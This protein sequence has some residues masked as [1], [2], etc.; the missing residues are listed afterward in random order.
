MIAARHTQLLRAIR[1]AVLGCAGLTL[2]ACS[3]SAEELARL[4]RLTELQER[5]AIADAEEDERL[6][7]RDIVVASPSQLYGYSG[8]EL[9]EFLEL[10]HDGT[11]LQPV[12]SFYHQG[13]TVEIA[14]VFRGRGTYLPDYVPLQTPF[15]RHHDFLRIYRPTYAFVLIDGTLAWIANEEISESIDAL[16]QATWASAAPENTAPFD[17]LMAILERERIEGPV[18]L[19]RLVY[20]SHE[21]A[22]ERRTRSHIVTHRSAPEGT[23]VYSNLP[24]NFLPSLRNDR[25]WSEAALSSWT[26]YSFIEET[27]TVGGPLPS[28]PAYYETSPVRN[29]LV[30]R[31]DLGADY[32]IVGLKLSGG[33]RCSPYGGGCRYE[34]ERHLWIGVRAGVVEWFDLDLFGTGTSGQRTWQATEDVC[35]IVERHSDVEPRFC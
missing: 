14:L 18:R 16:A 24:T 27:L 4:E 3:T 7:Y 1:L 19:A 20:P 2:S 33:D 26:S 21:Q 6:G 12:F 17:H 31:F 32:E 22:S 5:M 11:S 15:R 30:H 28:W 29:E 10:R 34:R 9:G 35:R 8:Q 13:Q 23:S 25:H